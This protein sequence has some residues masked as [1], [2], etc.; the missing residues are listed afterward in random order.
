MYKRELNGGGESAFCVCVKSSG[1][2]IIFC[3]PNNYV[4]DNIT[5]FSLINSVL[6][7]INGL[8]A[9]LSALYGIHT[10]DEMQINELNK[11]SKLLISNLLN[12]TIIMV[13][14]IHQS[15]NLWSKARQ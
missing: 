1:K 6:T 14:T 8:P 13:Y 3:S 4:R 12:F 9:S 10:Y 2:E 7:T 11:T 5:Q 15:F